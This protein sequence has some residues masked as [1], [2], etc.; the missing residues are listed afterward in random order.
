MIFGIQKPPP[1][2]RYQVERGESRD[3][4]A[5]RNRRKQISGLTPEE[6]AIIEAHEDKIKKLQY[7]LDELESLLSTLLSDK[8]DLE[9]TSSPEETESYYSDVISRYGEKILDILNTGYSYQEKIQAVDAELGIADD[10]GG[11]EAKR[12][13]D[14]Y[15]FYHGSEES[16]EK[17]EQIQKNIDKLQRIIDNKNRAV[18]NLE[19]KI[20][21][22][23]NF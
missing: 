4:L 6:E 10:R 18:D 8:D 9:A 23:Q 11:R 22:L 15:I 7:D 13:V 19:S 12:I 21:N 14:E 3:I 1:Y 2:K 17:I 16:E 20:Y 5:R